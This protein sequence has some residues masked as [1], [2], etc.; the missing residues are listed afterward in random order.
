MKIIDHP[1]QNYSDRC[2][3]VD[4]IIVHY[5]DMLEAES[6]LQRLCDTKAQVSAH[7]LIAR[8]GTVYQLVDEAK[9]AYHAGVSFWKD[10]T[11][12][13]EYSIGIELDNP[14]LQHGYTIFPVV[15]MQALVR[16]IKDIRTRHN[17]PDAFILGHS[18]VAPMRKKD[19]GELFD[20][21]YLA[22]HGIGLWP[23]FEKKM[24][25]EEGNALKN[26]QEI[27]YV[28]HNDKDLPYVVEA[29]QRH[30]YPANVTGRLDV[31]TVYRIERVAHLMQ[32]KG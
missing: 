31:E 19:P 17:I 14:G 12:L 16:L 25:S 30:F 29:F 11:S 2:F 4:M 8:D 27:G 7:Y 6:A 9:K 1:S 32:G 28:F 15:Q 18:D 10:R 13:N 23:D 24:T 21:K 26:L 3:P 5:T 20:W 22:C